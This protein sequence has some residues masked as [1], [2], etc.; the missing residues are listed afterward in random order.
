MVVLKVWVNPWVYDKGLRTP[1]MKN[2]LVDMYLKVED[3][4]DRPNISWKRD[5]L[6]DLFYPN[7]VKLILAQ[8]PAVLRYD[9]KCWEH[10]KSGEYSAK[11]GYWLASRLKNP[12]L[13]LEGSLQPSL[14]GLKAPSSFQDKIFYVE[15][16]KQCT[17]IRGHGVF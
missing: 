9:Y 1:L 14:N 15:S 17:P 7:D 4:I 11:S 2:C 8:K 13:H 3:I 10:T 12:G 5:K 16:P 6:D